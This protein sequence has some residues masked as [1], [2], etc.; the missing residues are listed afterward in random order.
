MTSQSS[1]PLDES[2][3]VLE[4]A[5]IYRNDDWWKAVVRYAFEED[6]DTSEVAVYL[7]HNDEGW[8]RKN[9]YVM[10][11]PEA[12]N[13]DRQVINQFFTDTVSETSTEE[14]PV[15]DYYEVGAGETI[16]QSDGW[17]KAILKIVQKG[18]Y[19]TEEVMVYLWQQVDGDWRRRQKYTLKS[20]DRWANEVEVIESILDTDN[21]TGSDTTDVAQSGS[22][23]DAFT[24]PDE[25]QQLSREIDQHL[26]DNPIK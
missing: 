6:G 18:S 7:W 14:F 23:D 19:E 16:F 5:D 3:H 13:T 11:T 17:W 10:K 24:Q 22:E 12:W 25:F 8:T 9:K 2:L 26:S 20:E 15:S 1:L 21:L 4:S